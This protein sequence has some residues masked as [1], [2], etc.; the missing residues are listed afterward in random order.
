MD[1][2]RYVSFPDPGQEAT[3][4]V[5]AGVADDAVLQAGREGGQHV[6]G[7][8]VFNE[9]GGDY[10]FRVE[11]DAEVSAFFVEGSTG[12]VGVGTGTPGA[13][14]H[15]LTNNAA[16][17][18]MGLFQNAG[19]AA[20]FRIITST[21]NYGLRVALDNHF[22]V[23]D[24]TGG[25]EPILIEAGSPSNS[26][27]TAPGGVSFFGSGSFGSGAG[28]VFLGNRTT[29][30]T[31][32]PAGGLLLWSSAGRLS[33]WGNGTG[34]VSIP[35]TTGGKITGGAPFTNDGYIECYIGSNFVRLM[36]TA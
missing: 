5:L 26:V 31:S 30:P 33:A 10:D 15:V 21:R 22:R 3:I 18:V 16:E 8:V 35:M 34:A 2:I 12:R 17:Q 14:L 29:A 36:T 20:Q 28:V 11:S 25:T 23:R 7:G 24:V 9:D 27:R 6:E 13:Q 4:R 1:G 19:G 32:Q